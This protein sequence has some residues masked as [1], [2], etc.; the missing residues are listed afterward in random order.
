[1]S[2][3]VIVAG[4][5]LRYSVMVLSWSNTLSPTLLGGV[6]SCVIEHSLIDAC[7]RGPELHPGNLYANVEQPGKLLTE[8]G[9]CWSDAE[10][11]L[12]SATLLPSR[13]AGNEGQSWQDAH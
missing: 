4:E 11:F 8:A 12:P 7:S 5:L 10:C 2:G 1:M 6:A 9:G 3:P 13:V